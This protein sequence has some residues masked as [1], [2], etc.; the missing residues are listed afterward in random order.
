V[1]LFETGSATQIGEGAIIISDTNDDVA[2]LR[3]E[4]IIRKFPDTAGRE[5][6]R[7]VVRPTLG[8][9]PL[10]ALRT[11]LSTVKFK[12]EVDDFSLHACVEVPHF[13]EAAAGPAIPVFLLFSIMVLDVV[14]RGG[15]H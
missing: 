11:K 12:C 2:D 10:K 15:Q 8:G 9:E 3:K 1:H 5:A 13:F 4:A 14:A 7:L 6:S